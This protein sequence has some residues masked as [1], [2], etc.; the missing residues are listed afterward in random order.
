MSFEQLRTGV[1]DLYETLSDILVKALER[2]ATRVDLED[3][4]DGGTGMLVISC[5]SKCYAVFRYY[6][7]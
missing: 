4:L 2:D 3:F 6:L 1:V 7:N 5:E